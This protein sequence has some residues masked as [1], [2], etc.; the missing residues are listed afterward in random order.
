MSSGGGQSDG[1]GSASIA[2]LRDELSATFRQ[3]WS[4]FYRSRH[5]DGF[6]QAAA[7]ESLK[8]AARGR[9]SVIER[10]RQASLA[11]RDRQRTQHGSNFVLS[12]SMTPV[13]SYTFCQPL[14]FPLWAREERELQF[15]PV[16]PEPSTKHF[17]VAAYRQYFQTFAWDRADRD[18]D[19]QIILVETLKR[20][21]QARG[22]GPLNAQAIDES[23]ALP[24]TYDEIAGLRE[25]RD[26]P[27]SVAALWFD[28]DEE[29][30]E[31]ESRNTA[32]LE[33]KLQTSKLDQWELFCPNAA[34]RSYGCDLHIRDGRDHVQPPPVA[35]DQALQSKSTTSSRNNLRESRTTTPARMSLAIIPPSL[36]PAPIYDLQSDNMAAIDL[37][38]H[39]GPCTTLNPDCICA[40]SNMHCERTCLCSPACARRHPGCDCHSRTGK[41]CKSETCRCFLDGRECDPDVCG[42]CGADR[43]ACGN[44]PI[45]AGL[46]SRYPIRVGLSDIQGYGLFAGEKAIPKDAP[47]IEYIGEMIDHLE[48]HK[49]GLVYEAL[50]RNYL[51]G[52]NNDMCLDGFARANEG[53]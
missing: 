18:P 25:E 46:L 52:L 7:Q 36:S 17:N 39:A 44:V 27:A 1:S 21:K 31:P 19:L 35:A 5:A 22:G 6:L 32:A 23:E 29:A 26:L 9:K 3:A 50:G 14:A 28:S 37:C 24:L 16:I 38:A 34:C 8:N 53:R 10:L 41:A 20:F 48:A 2:R 33:T 15:L 11:P 43:L 49:R 45:Q 51:F 13:P 47:I 30:P 40:R 4:D 12:S 42:S